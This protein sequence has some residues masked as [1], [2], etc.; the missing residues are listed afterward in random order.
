MIVGKDRMEQL[1]LKADFL[2]LVQELK[3]YETEEKIMDFMAGMDFVNKYLRK[4]NN[5]PIQQS[6]LKTK[7]IQ[8]NQFLIM[9]YTK[10]MEKELIDKSITFDELKEKLSTYI[11]MLGVTITANNKRKSEVFNI[12][13][14][15]S[16][17]K[18]SSNDFINLN[19][20]SEESPKTK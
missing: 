12:Q 10:K 3:Q 18:I 15:T 6:M 8:I 4:K 11:S 17:L 14:L 16:A 19:I 1:Y 7:L 9:C 13:S 20:V 2:G 5:L